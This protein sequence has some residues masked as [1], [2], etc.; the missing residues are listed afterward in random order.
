LAPKGARKCLSPVNMLIVDE[1]LAG[2]ELMTRRIFAE[3]ELID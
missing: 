2:L 3:P 1:L